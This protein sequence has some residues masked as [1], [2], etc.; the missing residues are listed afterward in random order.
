MALL[1]LLIYNLIQIKQT[2]SI[3]QLWIAQSARVRNTVLDNYCMASALPYETRKCLDQ[4]R[5][6]KNPNQARIMY[7]SSSITP[8]RAAS[9]TVKLNPCITGTATIFNQALKSCLA[10]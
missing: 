8:A 10:C 7:E 1:E 3:I 2:P 9:A 5:P 6:H 4:S